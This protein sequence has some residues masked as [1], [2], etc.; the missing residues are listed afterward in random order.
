MKRLQKYAQIAQ[1]TASVQLSTATSAGAEKWVPK[2]PPVFVT[3]VLPP[4]Y[5]KPLIIRQ[6]V[7]A[8]SLEKPG[9]SKKGARKPETLGPDVLPQICMQRRMPVS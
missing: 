7:F 2:T 5:A 1:P 8:T 4:K 9:R 3:N 6:K